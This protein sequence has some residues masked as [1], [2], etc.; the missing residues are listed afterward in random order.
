MNPV[1]QRTYGSRASRLDELSQSHPHEVG[2]NDDPQDVFSYALSAADTSVEK[3]VD[4]SSDEE[5]AHPTASSLQ[6][7]VKMTREVLISGRAVVFSEEVQYLLVSYI[8]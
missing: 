6:P 8:A 3:D 2:S 7:N 5:D 4:T 1:V